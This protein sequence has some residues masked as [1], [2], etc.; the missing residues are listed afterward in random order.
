MAPL[1]T[2][3]CCFGPARPRGPTHRAVPASARPHPS[4]PLPHALA[5]C[6]YCAA[7]VAVAQAH[8]E[9]IEPHRSSFA[10]IQAANNTIGAPPC[11]LDATPSVQCN[12]GD[13]NNN[14]SRGTVLVAWRAALD[15][16][17]QH[18]TDK[19][20]APPPRHTH[21]CRR[22]CAVLPAGLHCQ[23]GVRQL[24]GA[25]GFP[26]GPTARLGCPEGPAGALMACDVCMCHAGG[27]P[28]GAPLWAA[29][30]TPMRPRPACCRRGACCGTPWPPTAR[31]FP[32][33]W[34]VGAKLSTDAALRRECGRGSKHGA[35]A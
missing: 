26:V 8:P 25:R 10:T 35:C 33:C 5:S 23:P 3:P 14:S 17:M 34:R 6:S 32:C 15:A 30:H 4:A 28:P 22:H 12:Q 13:D 27:A 7:V 9:L 21:A 29:P 16:A 1:C 18:H 11:P 31:T 19:P 20:T 2:L 24:E